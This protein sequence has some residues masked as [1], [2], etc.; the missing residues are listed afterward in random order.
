MTVSERPKVG[1]QRA[2]ENPMPRVFP[3]LA[4]SYSA[5]IPDAVLAVWKKAPVGPQFTLSAR[6]TLPSCP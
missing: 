4:A 2:A 5:M 6:I 1:L 3:D